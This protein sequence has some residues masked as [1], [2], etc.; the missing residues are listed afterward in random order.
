MKN[1]TSKESL[2]CPLCLG[3]SSTP[4]LTDKTRD[5]LTCPTCQLIHV[6]VHQYLTDGAEKAQYDLH[7]NNPDDAGYRQFLSRVSQP[8]L[9]RLADS[10]HGLDFGCGPGPTLSVMMELAGHR[11]SL[12][13]LFYH[14]D[15][16]ALKVSYD[17]ITAT[18]VVEH[19]AKPGTELDRL[20][21][22]LKP[23]GWLAIMTKRATD[24]EGFKN[25]HYKADPTHISFFRDATFD[26][27]GAKWQSSPEFLASDV[28]FF[29]KSE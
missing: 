14:P 22:L 2:F 3:T 7:K 19:L 29:Q 25:W 21:S 13:D 24:F 11:V 18:E 10:S 16:H 17:F 4:F 9:E 1:N 15:T 26:W 27:L 6:P 20:W 8:L 12:Y 5:Y 23:A 28:V